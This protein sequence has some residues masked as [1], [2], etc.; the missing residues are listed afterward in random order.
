MLV[1]AMDGDRVVFEKDMK[2]PLPLR[3][4]L[5]LM[6]DNGRCVCTKPAIRVG[7]FCVWTFHRREIAAD[8]VQVYRIGPRAAAVKLNRQWE[9]EILEGNGRPNPYAGVVAAALRSGGAA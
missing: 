4:Q 6:S 5:L 9:I 2:E 8:G 1:R 7:A 3:I